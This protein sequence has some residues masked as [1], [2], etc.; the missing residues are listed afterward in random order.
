MP[1]QVVTSIENNFTKGLISEAT[2]LNF[3]ENAVTATDNCIYDERARVTRRLGFEFETNYEIEQIDRTTSVIAGFTWNNVAGDG[4]VSIRVQ[5]VGDMIY[6]YNV[7]SSSSSLS[8]G[9]VGDTVDLNDFAAGLTVDPALNE[10]QFAAG[11][12][13]LFVCHPECEPFYVEYDLATD[14]ITATAITVGIRDFDGVDDGYDV[15][16]RPTATVGTLTAAHKY[17]L[18]NQGW[19]FDSNAA[20]TTWDAARTDMPSNSDVWWNFKNA[21]DEFD[22]TTVPNVYTGGTP[23]PRGH[24]IL[25]PFDQDRSTVSGIATLDTV[26]TGTARFS[27]VAFMAGRIFYAG[28]SHTGYSSKIFFSPIVEHPENFGQCYQKNDPTS[29]QAFDL[30][31]ADGG[32]I[33][34]FGLERVVKLV[35]IVNVLLVFGSNGIWTITG[36]QGL[37]FTATDYAITKISSINSLSPSNFID[38]DAFPIWWNVEGI[39]ML[40]PAQSG[41]TG[42]FNISSLT[43]GVIRTFFADI[44][45]KAKTL[46]RGSYN[47][48]ERTF[49]WVYK[50]EATSNPQLDSEYDRM[51]TYNL[52]TKAWYGWSVDNTHQVKIHDLFVIKGEGGVQTEILVIDGNGN[53]VTDG[54]GNQLSVFSISRS[55]I[56]PQY[57]YYVS[58][59]DDNDHYQFTFAECKN[60]AYL[61]WVAYDGVGTDYDSTFTTGFKITGETQRFFQSNYVFVFLEQE[62]D[63]SCFMRGIWDW[64]TSSDEGKFSVSQQIYNS[65]LTNRVMNFRRLKVRGKGRALQLDFYSETGKPFTIVGWSIWQTSNASI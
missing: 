60:T 48:R 26:T 28:V 22:T 47:S 56:E 27:A 23:A 33:S 58:Y 54:S 25:N 63:A 50:S 38:F 46:A 20:L 49:K 36:S 6:F 2:G 37:G 53:P 31:A 61:D 16:E 59:F 55:V 51:L 13:F 3:P 7:V 57:K 40:L 14:T 64:T 34:I 18:F 10:C 42:D 45:S 12:G 39:Y 65:A 5:Q 30:L 21:D 32:V 62:D 4:T 44:S 24:Y 17:N 9:L 8:R 41:Q 11:N 15:D 35:P 29:E 43:D 19:Y 52:L 1:R